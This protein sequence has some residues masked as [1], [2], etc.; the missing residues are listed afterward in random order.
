MKRLVVGLAAHVDAGKTT[1]SEAV[2]YKTGMLRTAGRVDNGN[3]FL[4]TDPLERK[5]GITIFSKQAIIRT[6]AAEITLVD[7]PGHV[8]FSAETERAV[9][10]MDC[11]VLVIS[12]TDGVQSH[13]RTLWELLER[14]GVPVFVFVNKMDI[15]HRGKDSLIENISQL[16]GNFAEYCGT[17]AEK[18]AECDE[19]CM[20]AFLDTGEVPENLITKAISGRRL[21]PVVFGSAMKMNGIES[22][23]EAINRFAE[24]KG[25]LPEFGAI[26]W[27]ITVEEN[28]RLT[29]LKITGGTL[30]NRSVITNSD[31]QITQLRLYNGTKFTQAD[32]CEAGQI[33]A[34]TGLSDTFA[35]QAL[36]MQEQVPQPLC[37]AVLMYKILVPDGV[38]AALFFRKLKSLEVEEPQVRFYW[39]EATEEIHVS[40][41]GEVQLEILENLI[42]K[43][44]SVNVSFTDGSVSY[45]ETIAKECYGAGHFEPLRHYAEVHLR[46]TPLP[47]GSGIQFGDECSDLDENWR[48]SILYSLREKQHI[49]VLTGSP[50][51]DIKITLVAGRSHPKHTEGGD[52][53]QAALRAVRQ[54]LASAESVLLEPFYRFRL[55]VPSEC[56]GRAMTDLRRMGAEFAQRAASE[57][58]FSALEGQCP[59]S[60][61]SNYQREV[62][63]YSH[64]R[65]RLSTTPCGY[66]LCHNA[67]SIIQQIGYNF[68]S[69]VDN[70]ADSVF[71]FHGA[72]YLVKWDEAPEKMHI[73]LDLRGNSSGN[74]LQKI[75]GEEINSY[76]QRA[77]SDKELME[78]FERT[79]GKINRTERTAMRRDR[80]I[81]K[82]VKLPPPKRG[83]EFLLVD[84]YNI[85]FSW[86][87]LSRIASQNLDAARAK[88][89][90]ILCNYQGFKQNNVIL[91]FDA[92]KVKSEREFEKFGNLSVIYT[93]EAETADM[94]IEKTA[95]RLS[96]E[97]RVR[98]ASSDGTEQLIILGAGAVRVSA[99]EFKM[100]VDEVERAIRKILEDYK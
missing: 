61:M 16:G 98:V 70:P 74:D 92:Y 21:F 63:A 93:R 68:E 19:E 14:F 37:E 86:E 67:V 31:E 89:I 96:G 29:H 77:A 45:R 73:K 88:L 39:K 84:G 34:V 18:A 72:G 30:K 100:E 80:Q 57:E 94:F 90:N 64:G 91:V 69:D 6:D 95:Q 15:S 11:A 53:R 17:L 32:E 36:G 71:C 4:D 43:R 58:N 20:N 23:V 42:A 55:E 52:F 44:F 3:A 12:G 38:D 97:N 50:V 2:L 79:Y 1:L 7:T 85:I 27:K 76:K 66:F 13:T 65:G 33:V 9:A 35:G 5:R 82:S 83:P 54:G 51:S 26:V 59:V 46:L 60:E 81:E 78:I 10:I 62:S 40:V 99:R 49:G 75:T 48:R 8:D 25:R 47:A 56:V 87:E 22:L 41:M 28:V 24:P